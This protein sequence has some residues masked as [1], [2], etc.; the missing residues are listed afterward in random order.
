MPRKAKSN[1]FHCHAYKKTH[2]YEN[3]KIDDDNRDDEEEMKKEDNGVEMGENTD[4]EK[5]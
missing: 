3:D 1:Q 5:I 4:R 2:E